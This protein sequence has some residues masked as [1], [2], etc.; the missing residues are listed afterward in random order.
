MVIKWWVSDH[1][2]S[3]VPCTLLLL[4]CVRLLKLY[5]EFC[6]KLFV[7]CLGV[8][9][10]ESIVLQSN[11]GH[12]AYPCTPIRACMFNR[13]SRVV[14]ELN[15]WM[16]SVRKALMWLEGPILC[17]GK[18]AKFADLLWRP[19]KDQIFCTN[20]HY[21][22]VWVIKKGISSSFQPKFSRGLAEC[23]L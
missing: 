13:Y 8:K 16:F 22:R 5:E 4:E 21:C 11:V 17:K 20:L 6:L 12:A 1:F 2:L 15:R 10:P 3:S 14:L 23:E 9:C 19:P 7:H 18:W